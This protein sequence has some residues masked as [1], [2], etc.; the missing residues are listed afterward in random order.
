MNFW[1]TYFGAGMVDQYNFQNETPDIESNLYA[2]VPFCLSYFLDDMFWLYHMQT[3]L[4]VLRI[5]L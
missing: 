3:G 1:F 5:L 4:L 2:L